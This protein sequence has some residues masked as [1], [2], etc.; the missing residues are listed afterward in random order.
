MSKTTSYRQCTLYRPCG[1]GARKVL[2]SHIPETFAQ[3]GS[4]LK[5]KQDDDT[6]EDGWIVEEVG[7][8]VD[9]VELPNARKAIRHHRKATG[10]ALPKIAA[11]TD[12]EV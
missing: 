4:V 3:I 11:K 1:N 2:V 8:K 9:D 6:W 12:K 10:D 5:L 7:G